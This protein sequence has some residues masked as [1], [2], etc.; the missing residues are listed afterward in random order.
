MPFYP[1]KPV[2]DGLAKDLDMTGLNMHVFALA[3]LNI[4]EDPQRMLLSGLA[5]L[6]VRIGAGFAHKCERPPGYGVERT[7]GIIC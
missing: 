7:C 6:A 2:L 3:V 4:A 5:R 1:K